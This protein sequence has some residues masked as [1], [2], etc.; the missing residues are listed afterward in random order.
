MR[1]LRKVDVTKLTPD[2]AG[3]IQQFLI[4]HGYD[5]GPTGADKNFGRRSKAA[6]ADYNSKYKEDPL[7]EW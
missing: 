1:D 5:L 2:E 3:E 4:S 6:L 7:E